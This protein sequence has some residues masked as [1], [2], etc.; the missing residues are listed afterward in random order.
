VAGSV[1]LEDSTHMHQ[2][3]VGSVDQF[4][5]KRVRS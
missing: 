3:K 4:T 5:E 2:V 1:G